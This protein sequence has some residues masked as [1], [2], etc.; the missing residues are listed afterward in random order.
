MPPYTL[1]TRVE[2]KYRAL[3]YRL[4]GGDIQDYRRDFNP[5]TG[6]R[7]GNVTLLDTQIIEITKSERE[8]SNTTA[9]TIA[10]RP[11][12]DWYLHAVWG[13]PQAVNVREPV[14]PDG[15]EPLPLDIDEYYEDATHIVWRDVTGMHTEQKSNLT[16]V[17]GG[18]QT[19]TLITRR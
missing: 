9:A 15:D 5:I 19:I 12:P 2:T 13:P 11:G 6:Q 10:R 3:F 4:S 16:I 1:A 18:P 14:S 7:L 17:R 8:S